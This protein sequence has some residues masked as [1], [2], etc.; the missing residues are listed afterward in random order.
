MQ[1]VGL[2]ASRPIALEQPG[3]S[4]SCSLFSSALQLEQQIFGEIPIPYPTHLQFA[5]SVSRSSLLRGQT[6]ARRLF[7]GMAPG[8]GEDSGAATPAAGGDGIE[9]LPDEVLHHILGFLEAHE[10]V[11]TFVLARRWRHLWKFATGMRVV[12]GDG[13]FLG[14]VEKVMEFAERLQLLREGSLLHTCE[15]RFGDLGIHELAELLGNDGVRRVNTWLWNAVVT[16][17]ARDLR[18]DIS[19]YRELWVELDDMSLNSQ[20]LTRLQLAGVVVS[21]NFLNFPSCPA[22]EYLEFEDSNLL[23][24][25]ANGIS[26]QSLK[27]LVISGCFCHDSRMHICAPNLISLHMY[28]ITGYTPVL[29]S[30]PS[31]AEAFIDIG[32]DPADCSECSGASDCEFCDNSYNIGDCNWK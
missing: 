7:D 20:H 28:M 32:V 2:T 21:S 15:L 27:H 6:H 4:R 18:L 10:A 14:S 9:A 16:H 31:L 8:G 17:K 24:P 1:L 25:L 5:A 23:S 19:I 22:L 26:S 30:M 11:R 3:P 13:E 12:G 29:E